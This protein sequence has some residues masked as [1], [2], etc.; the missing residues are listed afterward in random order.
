MTK[1]VPSRSKRGALNIKKSKQKILVEE[2][3]VST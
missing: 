1:V 2:T 3:L